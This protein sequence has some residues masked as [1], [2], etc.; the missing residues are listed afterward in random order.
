MLGAGGIGRLGTYARGVLLVAGGAARVDD[1]TRGSARVEGVVRFLLD[2]LRE[3]RLG[4][5]AGAGVSASWIDG[6]GW[7]T[8]LVVAFGVE[9][10][11]RGGHALAAE[12]G[13]GGGA[14]LAL[15]LRGAGPRRR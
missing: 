2:P 6:D 12:V 5:Y 3:R 8:P 1:R 15:V 4:A 10:P 9:G 13:L 11:R 7:R 14:R